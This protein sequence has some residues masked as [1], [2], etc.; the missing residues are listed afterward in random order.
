M[1]SQLKRLERT[2]AVAEWLDRR[3]RIPLTPFHIGMDGLIGLIPGFGDTAM[4]ACSL[5]ILYQSRRAGAPLWLIFRMAINIAI[6][7]LIGLIPLVG[8]FF[9]IAWKANL[10]NVRLLERYLETAGQDFLP[11]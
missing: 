7:W 10:K 4:L 3:F 5:W 2:R 11:G 8:D 1:A 9:D 6:D